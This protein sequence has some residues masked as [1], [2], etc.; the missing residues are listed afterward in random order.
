M[1]EEFERQPLAIESFAPNL[2]MHVGPQ[3]PAPM[4][5][6]AA[7]GMV[8]APP[9]Q[10][11]RVLYQLHFDAALAQAVAD[12]LGGMP[13]AV[14]VPALQT[15]QPAGVLDWIA[16]L[17]QEAAVMQAVVLN[18]GTD[19][20]T[21]VQLAGQ[22]SADVCDV[23]ANN[24]V[25][26]LRTPGIIEALYTNS[27]ARMATV[28]KLIDLAQR[29]GVELGGLPGLAEAL[30]SGEALDAEGGL[31][32]AAFAGVL[33]KE[34]VRTRG[35]EEMLSKLDD[36]SLTRSERER[37]QREIGGGD[38][39]EEVVEERRRKGSLFSQIGQMNLAQ[40]IRL[41]SV[42]SREAINILVRDS[43]KLVHM[44]AIRS[45]RLRP[46]DIRQ[47]ASNK[48]IP[49]GVIKYIA[50]NRDWTRHYD[51]MV[52]LTMN[53]KTP[54]SDVMSFLN[55][56]RTKD[57]RDLTRNRNVSHQVQRMAKSLVN[58]RGGR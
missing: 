48:S 57:L 36:P 9:E 49:E 43:N 1:S 50:M 20:R 44:A 31:D 2:R 23:I 28:D 37:L 58:K 5:M 52:S 47:L 13:E 46:A 18:K 39:D 14:L 3:A 30:R 41:S 24:Q 26:V 51:V 22:A 21:V 10:L 11:V 53:P 25:R 32:D 34:R 8:P 15:E 4:K 27:H 45:P 17:R 54:L 42:G 7:R 56:L 29:N 16:E 6:M 19:D 38:E 55:H 35:E 12:A 33:E 40:K